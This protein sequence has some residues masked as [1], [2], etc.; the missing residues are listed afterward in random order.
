MTNQE[1]APRL[2]L[3]RRRARAVAGR[4]RL[5]RRVAARH[6]RRA[7]RDHGDGR[8]TAGPDRRP[9]ETPARVPPGD[10]RADGATPG[11]AR[12]EPAGGDGT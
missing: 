2:F 6:R 4:R 8:R 5:R 12:A 1:I 7:V 3:S 10:V 9:G 11:V